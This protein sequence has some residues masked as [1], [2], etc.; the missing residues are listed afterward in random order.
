MPCKHT[1]TRRERGEI[2][3]RQCGLVLDIMY[4]HSSFTQETFADHHLAGGEPVAP[5]RIPTGYIY[6]PQEREYLDG[7]DD[8]QL[9]QLPSFVEQDALNLWK[10]CVQNKI[11]KGRNRDAV[12]ESCVYLA[13]LLH[14]KEYDLNTKY[15]KTIKKHFSLPV[16]I[17]QSNEAMLI[18]YGQQL[19]FPQELI[20]EAITIFNSQHFH[21]KG[22][23]TVFCGVFYYLSQQHNVGIRLIE[24]C[25]VGDVTL[26]SVK[27]VSRLVEEH[28]GKN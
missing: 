6:S 23:K 10:Q 2:T 21:K 5:K 7:K 12:L 11:S 26:E 15:A 27:Q 24:L 28:Y 22:M 25:R 14:K 16:V 18:Q 13:G 19:H 4:D 20:K 17:P 3:C 8:I 9:M 1:Q